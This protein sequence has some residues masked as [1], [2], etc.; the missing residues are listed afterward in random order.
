M[1]PRRHEDGGFTLIELSLIVL[2]VAALLAVLLPKLING[3]RS[4]RLSTCQNNLKQVDLAHHLWIMD[5]EVNRFPGDISTN[6]GGKLECLQRGDLFDYFKLFTNNLSSPAVLVCPSERR[7]AASS[8]S[9]LSNSNL[10]YF[11]NGDIG[12]L[13]RTGPPDRPIDAPLNPVVLGDRNISNNVAG[14]TRIL[15]V[16]KT[17]PARWKPE[18]H[19]YSRK[20]SVALTGNIA[21]VDGSAKCLTDAELYEAFRYD[22]SAAIVLP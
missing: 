21:F 4:S 22:P 1:I 9:V 15:S 14:P 7:K 17:N 2:I 11:A 19:N 12:P 10:S 8:F 3:K 5:H 13:S 20:N 16:S 18:M 6:A